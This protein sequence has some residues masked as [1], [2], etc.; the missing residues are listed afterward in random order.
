MKIGKQNK[1][2]APELFWPLNS[3][4]KWKR[5]NKENSDQSRAQSGRR[6]LEDQPLRREQRKCTAGAAVGRLVNNQRLKRKRRDGAPATPPA[7]L[8]VSA[9]SYAHLAY[10]NWLPRLSGA[11]N[12]SARIKL[13]I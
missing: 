12:R 9:L 13:C 8:P 10:D 6:D 3:R 1:S 2:R 5:E 4:P 7:L 11:H